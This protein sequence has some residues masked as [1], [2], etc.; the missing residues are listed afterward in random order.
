MKN[1]RKIQKRC[2]NKRVEEEV[3][4][5]IIERIKAASGDLGISIGSDE[6]TKEEILESVEEGSEIGQEIMDAQ[7]E[8][9]RDMAEG[10]IYKDE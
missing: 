7:M 9:L 6:Y 8:Y 3:R 1:N 5:L 4:E 10:K 2:E